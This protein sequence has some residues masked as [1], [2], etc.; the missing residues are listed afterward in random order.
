MRTLALS[1]L[2]SVAMV[3]ADKAAQP[4]SEDSLSYVQTTPIPLP[5]VPESVRA[6]NK[7]LVLDFYRYVAQARDYRDSNVLK[8][9]AP[10]FHNHDPVEPGT[11][12]G[13]AAFWRALLEIGKKITV[14]HRLRAATP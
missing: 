12:A 1:L 13:Y 14:G 11:A 10:S 6:A 9:L 7:Q 5:D 2:L 3:A 8:Y 4:M